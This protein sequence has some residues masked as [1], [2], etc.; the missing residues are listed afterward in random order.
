MAKSAEEYLREVAEAEGRT[1]WK[2]PEGARS[3]PLLTPEEQKEID[4]M[5]KPEES[6]TNPEEVLEDTGEASTPEPTEEGEPTGESAL[7]GHP[8]NEPL[9]VVETSENQMVFPIKIK[10]Y[11]QD[12]YVENF[13]QAIQL[14][15]MGADY[16]NKMHSLRQYR[17]DIL[18]VKKYP[19][20]QQLI[21][22]AQEGKEIT[23][24]IHFGERTQQPISSG[25]E[26]PQTPTGSGEPVEGIELRLFDDQEALDLGLLKEGV[27]KIASATTSKSVQ[28]I[29][30]QVQQLQGELQSLRKLLVYNRLKAEDEHFEDTMKSID[31]LLKVPNLMPQPLKEVIMTKPEAFVDFYKAVRN[32]VIK[33]KAAGKPL[34]FQKEA[35]DKAPT[36]EP[37]VTAQPLVT[38]PTVGT[39]QKPETPASGDG[40]SEVLRRSKRTPKPPVLESGAG[41]VSGASEQTMKDMWDLTDEQFDKLMRSVDNKRVKR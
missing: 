8:N 38:A 19:V 40:V 11:K 28:P 2:T 6:E 16:S 17:N 41:E 10:V 18:T 4:A 35:Y 27:A 36:P 26:A 15:Q 23:Q 20:L 5:S 21:Q 1:P 25:A 9:P 37:V 29:A 24:Y 13:E 12:Y 39:E 30:E 33:L 22:L 3:F 7:E 31:F 14:M 32:E 34:I